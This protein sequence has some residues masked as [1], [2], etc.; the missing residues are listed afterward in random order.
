MNDRLEVISLAI[1]HGDATLLHWLPTDGP[2]FSVL[3]DG[4][5]SPKKLH[6]EL[7]SALNGKDKIDL[8]VLT[9]V[10][11]DH[12][13]GLLGITDVFEVGTY[14]GPCLEA[15][16]RYHW[17]FPPRVANALDRAGQLEEEL[18]K[19]GAEIV[20]PLEGYKNLSQDRNFSM[21]VISPPARLIERLLVNEDAIQLFTHYP[22]PQGWLLDERPQILEESANVSEITARLEGAVKVDLD[23]IKIEAAKQPKHMD[24]VRKQWASRWDAS[25]EFFGNP[26]LNDTSLVIVFESRFDGLRSKR[27]LFPGDLENWLYL[28]ARHTYGLGCFLLKAPHHGGRVFIEKDESFDE[29]YQWIRPEVVMV[30]GNGQHG[31]PRSEFRESARKWGATVFCPCKRSKE[32]IAGNVEGER[33]CH[34]VFGCSE[35]QTST[36]LSITSDSIESN[37]QACLSGSGVGQGVLPIVSIKQHVV[38]PSAALSR[39]T[40]GELER[41]LTWLR[42][43]LDKLHAAREGLVAGTTQSFLKHS[44]TPETI[45]DL[46]YIAERSLIIADLLPLYQLA[47]R[48]NKIWIA[49]WDTRYVGNDSPRIYKMPSKKE[50]EEIWNWLNKAKCLIVQLPKGKYTDGLTP[51]EILLAADVSELALDVQQKFYYPSEVFMTG[52]WPLFAQQ[53]VQQWSGFGIGYAPTSIVLS[54]LEDGSDDLEFVNLKSFFDGFEFNLEEG[55]VDQ[56]PL[57]ALRSSLKCDFA[58]QNMRR[59]WDPQKDRKK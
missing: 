35:A 7:K 56:L 1:G 33:S 26:V 12:L 37:N 18:R 22:M 47:K 20:Y 17:L 4:G 53:L 19:H 54:K 15:F 29:V 31:L 9:H 28:T 51:E 42:K 13:N 6:T 39:L 27:L 30:S 41:H 59:L 2:S 5:V 16:R 3:V 36:R 23:S 48:T 52:V 40:E 14:W 57:T 45:L 10:D 55:S 32:I 58:R 43:E 8:L 34:T 50:R 49:K 25:P 46:A 21:T 38:E 11:A 24:L 44:I